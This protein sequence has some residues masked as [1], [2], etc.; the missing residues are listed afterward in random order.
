MPIF[1]IILSSCLTV[2]MP[3]K[4]RDHRSWAEVVPGASGNP[5]F[6]LSRGD[7]GWH[8]GA[9]NLGV[10]EK[11]GVV[12]CDDPFGPDELGVPVL[13][14]HATSVQMI[15]EQ[16]TSLSQMVQFAFDNMKYLSFSFI[17]TGRKAFLMPCNFC[18]RVGLI[19]VYPFT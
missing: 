13:L 12:F 2:G 10:G 15:R 17:R 11:V 3:P 8:P 14:E 9:P 19:Q 5:R 16:E 7:G 4:N 1:Q 18:F 6:D